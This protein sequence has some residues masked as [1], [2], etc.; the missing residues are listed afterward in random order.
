MFKSTKEYKTASY[1]WKR[2]GSEESCQHWEFFSK[3]ILKRFLKKLSVAHCMFHLE[4]SSEL[5]VVT[6][7]HKMVA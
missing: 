1:T 4:Q 2:M 7:L 5:E 3:T 6:W